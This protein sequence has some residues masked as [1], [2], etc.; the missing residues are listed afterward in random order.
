MTQNNPTA[1]S[2][3]MKSVVKPTDSRP[4]IKNKK[5]IISGNYDQYRLY[6]INKRKDIHNSNTEYLYVNSVKDLVGL[7]NIQGYYIG[8]YYNRSDISKIQDRIAIIK[9]IQDLRSL[10]TWARKQTRRSAAPG[11]TA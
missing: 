9:Q 11:R 6:V 8:T 5:Y 2:E 7:V 4:M 3:I 1:S 10:H